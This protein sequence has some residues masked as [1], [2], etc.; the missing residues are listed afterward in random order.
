MKDTDC[1]ASYYCDESSA[2]GLAWHSCKP[3]KHTGQRCKEDRECM[4]HAVCS[5]REKTD[6]KRCMDMW[7]LSDGSIS[8]DP[9]LCVNNTINVESIC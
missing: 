6:K 7:V 2:S 5:R 4:N 9:L 3:V 8:N 1:S